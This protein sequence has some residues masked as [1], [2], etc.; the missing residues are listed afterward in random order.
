MVSTE[1][2]F[3][4]RASVPARVASASAG[5]RFVEFFAL[6]IRNPHTHCAYAQAA[7]D[8]RMVLSDSDALV[9]SPAL[10]AGIRQPH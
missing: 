3:P 8:S 10:S 9:R 7:G 2:A 1:L 4:A 5:V 6:A